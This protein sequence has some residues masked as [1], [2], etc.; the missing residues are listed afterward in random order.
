MQEMANLATFVRAFFEMA[1]FMLEFRH[2]CK[3]NE[4]TVPDCDRDCLY[5]HLL[6]Y[7]GVQMGTI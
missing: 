6:N 5:S 1:S 2:R 7:V 4:K 3:F